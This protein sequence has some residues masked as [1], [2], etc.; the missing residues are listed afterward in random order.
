M[1]DGRSDGTKLSSRGEK[2]VSFTF[3]TE[4]KRTVLYFNKEGSSEGEGDHPFFGKK[5]PAHLLGKEEWIF[6]FYYS[7]RGGGKE[8]PP[9]L[10]RGKTGKL[11]FLGKEE[12]RKGSAGVFLSMKIRAASLW[13]RGKKG[14]T[15]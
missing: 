9:P 11:N 7:G 14:E 5:D 1:T 2:Y 13:K 15:G 6:A 12:R 4:G 10:W 3:P 8:G